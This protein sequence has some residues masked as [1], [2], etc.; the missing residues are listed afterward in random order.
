MV[1]GGYASE[2]NPASRVYTATKKDN[3]YQVYA[4]NHKGSGQLL[5]AY[6]ICLSSDRTTHSELV[7]DN[8]AVPSSGTKGTETTCPSGM[9]ATGGGFAGSDG[10]DIYDD[11]SERVEHLGGLWLQYKA[12]IHRDECLRYLP[13]I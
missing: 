10:L 12:I 9:Y 6:A 2:G 4:K 5:N 11:E 13:G 3:G 8:V 7:W 1:G